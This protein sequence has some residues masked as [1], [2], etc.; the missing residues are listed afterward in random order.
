M[1]HTLAPPK[2]RELIGEVL[3]APVQ[4][5]DALICTSPAVRECLEGLLD[6][7]QDHLSHRFEELGSAAAPVASP[8]SGVDQVDLL[9][10]RVDMRSRDF[11]RRY[12][13]LREEDVLS[14]WLGR[15]SF[16]EGLSPGHVCCAPKAAQRCES[17]SSFRNGG[18][19]LNGQEDHD[20]FQEAARRHAPDVS[21]YFSDGKNP[22]VVRSCWAAADLFLFGR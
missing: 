14:L 3:I 5:W 1:I 13:R 12:L 22:D 2:V 15:L 16:G 21:A 19:V 8:A 6:R 9:D 10:Q 11:L 17:A 7:W 20:L 18:L 4:P